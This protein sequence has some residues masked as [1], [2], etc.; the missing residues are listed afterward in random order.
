MCTFHI[1]KKSCSGVGFI[2][3]LTLYSIHALHC[4]MVGHGWKNGCLLVLAPACGARTV[5]RY[6][7]YIPH[8]IK[9]WRSLAGWNSLHLANAVAALY[10][11]AKRSI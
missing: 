11:P 3:S 7:Y 10:K 1:R 2:V 9:P 5:A 6:A 4:G 8:T